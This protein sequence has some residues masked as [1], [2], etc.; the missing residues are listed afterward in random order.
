MRLKSIVREQKGCENRVL[1][2]E[3]LCSIS[4]RA[5]PYPRFSWSEIRIRKT[6]RYDAIWRLV[7]Y[8]SVGDDAGGCYVSE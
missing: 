3:G 6:Y 8:V 7:G 5:W 4:T 1:G 2:R